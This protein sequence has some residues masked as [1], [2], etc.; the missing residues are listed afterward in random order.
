MPEPE[1]I[2][3][4]DDWRDV[5]E[6]RPHWLVELRDY[7][8][9]VALCAAWVLIY[10]AMCWHQ[11]GFRLGPG[12]SLFGLWLP[13]PLIVGSI[14]VAGTAHFFGDLTSTELMQG[15]IWR[16]ITATF[17][18]YNLLHLV[19]NLLGLFLLGR[20]V[21]SW[22]GTGQFLAIYTIVGGLGNLLAGLVRPLFHVFQLV[23]SGGGSTVVFGLVAL[24][25]VAGW[26]SRTRFGD[27]VR[28]QMVL[29]LIINGLAGLYFW[30]YIDNFGHAGGTLVGALIGLAH[31]VLVRTEGRPIARV[32]G[33]LSAIVLLACM[34]A[35]FR[36]DRIELA[37]DQED[38]QQKTNRLTVLQDR[39]N[40]RQEVLARMV[41]ALQIYYL[42]AEAPSLA[43]NPESELRS[44]LRTDLARL[45]LLRN[46]L[47]R[48]PTDE[49]W[50][51][52]R[53]LAD[54][55]TKR[56][57][58]PAEENEFKAHSVSLI[59]QAAHQRDEALQELARAIAPPG[60]TIQVQP[61]EKPT[62]P[63]S[64]D[65]PADQRAP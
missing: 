23:H 16:T 24:M 17:I 61:A 58:T 47:V 14:D 62:P 1:K 20:I 22:Y 21:E 37:Q 41:E 53:W 31:P 33:L 49:T 18:H 46:T 50:L 63:D 55:A 48:E 30:H 2:Q 4:L 65:E 59:E 13:N 8:A 64:T 32:V 35:Q 34:G 25:A 51:R 39:L 11:Q 12:L 28:S 36:T 5:V 44:G 38:R 57:P 60:S 56:R 29:L 9:T 43:R 3:N 54:Q 27:Y 26:R 40:R 7:P 6:D 10:L 45:D 19:L 15:Q 42:L 52:W